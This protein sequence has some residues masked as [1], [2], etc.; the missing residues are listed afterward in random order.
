MDRVAK[1]AGKKL[2]QGQRQATQVQKLCFQTSQAEQSQHV[3]IQ[4]IGS[5]F[6][7]SNPVHAAKRYAERA[8]EVQLT[9]CRFAVLPGSSHTLRS[10]CA[11]AQL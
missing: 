9:L 1:R 5:M 6:R 8:E 2:Y 7:L 4:A 3:Y 10:L 11:P